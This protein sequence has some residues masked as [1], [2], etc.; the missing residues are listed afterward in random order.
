M[1][2]LPMTEAEAAKV[3][4]IRAALI[5]AEVAL[6]AA[7]AAMTQLMAMAQAIPNASA[8][9]KVYTHRGA[10]R[11]ILGQLENAHGLAAADLDVEVTDAGPVILAPGR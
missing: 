5:D 2:R 8:K 9:N 1:A 3:Q 4:E 7:L 6:R 10:F 11:A